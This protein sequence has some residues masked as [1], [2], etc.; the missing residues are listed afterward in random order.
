MRNPLYSGIYWD[1]CGPS[2]PPLKQANY[3]CPGRGPPH[4]QPA[5]HYPRPVAMSTAEQAAYFTAAHATFAE[6]E[7]MIAA[8]GKWST[9]A[10]AGESFS[11]ETCCRGC[12]PECS[13]DTYAQCVAKVVALVEAANLDNH[14]LQFKLPMPEWSA[15]AGPPFDGSFIERSVG[16]FL[17]VRGE[18]AVLV[19]GGQGAAFSYA[20]DYPWHAS[21]DGDFGRPLSDAPTL[22]AGPTGVPLS[23]FTREWSK[24]TVTMDCTTQKVEIKPKAQPVGV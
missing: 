19:M 18:A 3:P 5:C 13:P 21:L 4:A 23:M 20:R 9:T 12:K 11:N 17:L 1:Q 7:A 22:G 24:A 6:A 14:T 16:I 10:M 8:A 2:A 15:S